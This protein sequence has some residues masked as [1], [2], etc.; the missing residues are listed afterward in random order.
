MPSQTPER[1]QAARLPVPYHLSGAALELLRGRLLDLS[2]TG[3]RMEHTNLVHKGRV[4]NVD[5]PHTLGRCWLKGRVVWTKLHRGEQT[6]EGKARISY[7]TGLA[8]VELTPEQRATLAA[9]LEILRTG[10]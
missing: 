3:A 9:A 8:F 7:Q 6:F 4:C 1:R 10:E 2:A 5:L